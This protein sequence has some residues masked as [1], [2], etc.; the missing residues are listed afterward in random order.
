MSSARLE[1]R[2]RDAL[3]H[4]R[5]KFGEWVAVYAAGDLW[6]QGWRQLVGDLLGVVLGFAGQIDGGA[7]AAHC[8]GAVLAQG[9]DGGGDG[10]VQRGGDFLQ[11][12][13]LCGA[14]GWIRAGGGEYAGGGHFDRRQAQAQP[15]FGG[16][17]KAQIIADA[18]RLSRAGVDKDRHIG[19]ELR[20]QLRQLRAGC[21]K[22]PQP[23][24]PEQGGGGVGRA[25]AEPA[26]RRNAFGQRNRRAAIARGG[27]VRAQQFAGADD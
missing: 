15:G 4:R 21:A 12:V 5:R 18:A 6:A 3:L 17:G 9:F 20:A 1:A 13:A 2:V 16:G 14:R 7:A 26:A 11:V 23:I 19:A 27:K 25:A 24:E 10:G 22:V 8:R